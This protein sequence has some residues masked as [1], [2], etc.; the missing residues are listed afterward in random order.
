M[1]LRGR[2]L[3]ADELPDGDDQ[4]SARAQMQRRR[5][6]RDLP[7]GAVGVKVVVNTLCRKDER[8]RARREQMLDTDNRAF[9]APSGSLPRLYRRHALKEAHGVAG[10]IARRVDRKRMQAPGRDVPRDAR[11]GRARARSAHA[12]ENCRAWTRRAPARAGR[13]VPTRASACRGPT[14][15]RSRPCRHGRPRCCAT[16]AEVAQHRG[17]N[18]PRRRQRKAALTAP[19][20]VPQ[21]TRNGVVD[22]RP[23]M[24][25]TACS[26]P[27]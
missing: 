15:R 3:L 20:E 8:N 9:S 22:V 25:A 26:T 5:Q 2:R 10:G 19:A 24:L 18:C 6:R 7:H 23:S 13:P 27:I 4:H 1:P 21:I 12:V 14:P 17:E 11:R 16:D